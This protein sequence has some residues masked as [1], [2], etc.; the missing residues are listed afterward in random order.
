MSLDLVWRGLLKALVLPPGSLVLLLLF[1]LL[2]WRS[3]GRL[4]VLLTAAALY[5]LSTPFM[6]GW[7][8][9]GLETA[10][11]ADPATL[12]DQG[13][14]AIVVLLAGRQTAA[15]EA[16]GDTVSRLSM[17]R[18]VHAAR[19]QRATGLPVILSGGRAGADGPP[20]AELGARTLQ[21]DF[22][23]APLALETDSN[24]TWENA[25]YLAPLLTEQ[26]IAK[27]AVVTHAWHIPRA[28]YSFAQAGVAT[29]PAPTYFV[30][31]DTPPQW[32]DWLPSAQALAD[33]A[34]LLHEHLGLFWYQQVRQGS[35]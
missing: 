35:H 17:D 23:I 19:L 9:T 1:A 12:R 33:S 3:L 26:G 6:A 11:P 15:P 22:G 16:G 25:H 20:L 2:A 24:N 34:K 10:R 4:L 32:N 21:D 27:V 7:L 14:Q 28:E 8:A 30:H 31:R 13:V 5:L 18:L 29:L